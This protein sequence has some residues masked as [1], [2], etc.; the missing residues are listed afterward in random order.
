MQ[1]PFHALFILS[2]LTIS[3]ARADWPEFRGP[4]AQGHSD[5]HGLPI[6]W[7]DT[8][9]VQWKAAIPG[10]GW[11]SPVIKG[12]QIILTTADAEGNGLSLRVLSVSAKTGKIG[13]NTKIF[14]TEAVKHH[15][16][17]SDASPTPIIEGDR[18]YAHFGHYGTA[19]LDLKGKV[20]WKQTSLNYPPVHGN[21]GS[22]AL[23]DNALIYSGDGSSDPFIAALDK[24]TGKVLWKVPRQ[25]DAKKKFSFCT[26]LV[27]EVKGKKQVISPGSGVV[28]ALDPKDGHEIW[29]VRYG[30]GY[31]VVPRP[32]F[33]HGLLFL[34]SGFDKA[35]IYAIKPDGKG[36]VTD[37]HVAWTIDRGAPKTPSLLLV[38]DE[39]Y[40]VADNGIA[41]CADAR[42][43]QIHWQERVGGDY[44]ASPIYAD[45]RI[46]LQN[47]TGM[48]VVLQPGKQFKKLAE[49]NL[50]E[51][52]LASYAV[53]GSSLIIRGENNLFRIGTGKLAGK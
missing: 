10:K 45:G 15:K 37:T 27:I 41:L 32:I 53:D 29:R 51:A 52:T 35:V 28:C 12:D 31:S 38:G 36:D 13:W 4:T 25:T 39:V 2:A 6:E 20:L 43:G 22:P 11:S 1:R 9:N 48:G 21:G 49:N 3:I 23:V 46:Y 19:S 5:A 30:E 33:G 34:S 24:R 44:S 26:P 17:N 7:S 40:A 47:E 18:I 50:G 16:K 14:A 8:K 42:T